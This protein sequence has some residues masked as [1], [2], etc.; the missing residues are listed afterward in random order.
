MAM[1]LKQCSV[2]S[3]QFL[4]K[5]RYQIEQNQGETTYYCSQTCRHQQAAEN[6]EEECSTCGSAFVPKYAFQRGT[7]NGTDVHFCSM[8]CRNAVVED[9]RRKVV[10]QEH[11]PMRIAVLN[12]KG[13]TGKTTT[14]VTLGAGLVEAGYR[15]LIIDV[16]SQGHVGI[17]LGIK[18][19]K[20]LFHVLVEQQPLRDCVISAR[21]SL[22]VLPGNETLASTEIFLARLNEGRDRVLRRVLES[23]Q[24]YDFIILDCGPSL[25]LLNMN[26]LTFAEHLIVPVSCDFLSLVG[27]KQLLKTLKNVNQVLMHPIS[28]LGILPTFYDMRNNIS[29]ESVKTLR[30]YFHDKVL[31]PIRVNTRLK[32]APRHRKTIFEYAP[33]SRG[34]SDYKKL[35]RWVVEHSEKRLKANAS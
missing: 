6:G 7:R 18:G 22:D 14:A 20:T 9:V 3:K 24:G 28:I 11:G 1:A 13:G 35:I 17:S 30:G 21:P 2:C 27:V 10:Q 12:Q 32:E 33:E 8:E 19:E 5:F 34:A 25:S 16:D 29:D 26:A 23:E 31:P 15:V 4:V